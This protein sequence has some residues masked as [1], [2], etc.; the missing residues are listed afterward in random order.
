MRWHRPI[1]LS[2]ELFAL[3][4]KVTREYCD[5]FDDYVGSYMYETNKKDF[6]RVARLLLAAAK[7]CERGKTPTRPLDRD[8]VTIHRRTKDYVIH[9]P[10]SLA[11]ISWSALR[12]EASSYR[13]DEEM[14]RKLHQII[15]AFEPEY[16]GLNNMTELRA[17]RRLAAQKYWA[18]SRGS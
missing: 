16:T 10:L 7:K 13:I 2:P 15:L 14:E 5:N 11:Q 4:L 17:A 12:F 8:A 6:R 18:E 1:K 9:G 3:L